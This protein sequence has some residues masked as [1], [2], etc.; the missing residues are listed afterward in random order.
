M[1]SLNKTALHLFEH[2]NKDLQG[3]AEKWLGW[4]DMEKCLQAAMMADASDQAMQFTR[5]L[6]TEGTDPA[7]MAN[8]ANVFLQVVHSLFE[9]EPLHV[10]V[11]L[12]T[13]L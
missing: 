5:I 12:D 6:D 3:R 4:L 10:C 1:H 8:A 2:G 7:S 9:A 11:C 13:P